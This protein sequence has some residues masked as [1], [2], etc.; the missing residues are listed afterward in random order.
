M[1]RPGQIVFPPFRLETANERLYRGDAVVALRPKSFG[2]LC[3]LVERAGQLV[4]KDE[5]LDAVWHDVNVTDAVL[6]GCIRELRDAL[7]DDPEAPRFIET[8]HRR[9]YRFVGEV[10]S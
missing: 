10:T 4:T 2:V 6:K 5:L 3:H 8:A 1:T 7:D 9:G